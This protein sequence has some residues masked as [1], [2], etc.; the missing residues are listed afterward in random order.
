MV[1]NVNNPS[2]YNTGKIEVIEFIEDQ[3]LGFNR[4]NAIKYISRAG[5]KGDK[6]IEDLKKAVWYLNREIELLSAGVEGRKV[7]RPNDMNKPE[8][9]VDIKI[10]EQKKGPKD[11]NIVPAL[12]LYLERLGTLD[13]F[14]ARVLADNYDGREITCISDA[15]IWNRTPEGDRFWGE[16]SND[17]NQMGIEGRKVTCPNDMNKPEIST[18]DRVSKHIETA[19]DIKIEE[20]EKGPKEVNIV[21]ALKLYLE[22]SALLDTF[23]ARVLADNYEGHEISRIGDAFRWGSTPEGYVFWNEVSR[24]FTPCI[25][26][27]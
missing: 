10:E 22:K 8:I 11:V 9:S 12:K 27:V 5:K 25:G 23:C 21:P 16:V 1:N 26:Q 7:T 14:Y 24:G 3:K 17:F 4:G 19:I 6:E 13:A 20:Q 15:F 2:H 18:D